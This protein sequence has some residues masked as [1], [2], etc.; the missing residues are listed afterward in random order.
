MSATPD[1]I[2]A[3]VIKRKAPATVCLIQCYGIVQKIR[4]PCRGRFA[5][6]QY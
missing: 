5:S 6:C 4:G 2:I 3:N 1:I